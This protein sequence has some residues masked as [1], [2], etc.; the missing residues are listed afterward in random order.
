MEIYYE[1]SNANI[2]FQFKYV[3]VF[4]CILQWEGK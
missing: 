1:N 4:V 3:C 2:H